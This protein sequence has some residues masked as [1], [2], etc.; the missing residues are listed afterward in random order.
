MKDLN[1]KQRAHLRAL[2]HP[3]KPLFQI[4]KDGISV[5]TIRAV[6]DSFNRRELIKVRLLDAAPQ[7]TPGAARQLVDQLDDTSIVQTMGNVVT[8]YRPHP[9]HPEIRLPR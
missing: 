5:S 2:A 1:S 9:E 3:L 4:G 8:L 7:D 6:R